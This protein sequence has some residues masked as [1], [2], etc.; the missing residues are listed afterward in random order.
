MVWLYIIEVDEPIM[1]DDVLMVSLM[2]AA[3][4]SSYCNLLVITFNGITIDE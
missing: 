1:L 4:F 2:V 3:E